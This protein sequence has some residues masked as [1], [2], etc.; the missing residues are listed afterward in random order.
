MNDSRKPRGKTEYYPPGTDMP[1]RSGSSELR[2]DI[3]LTSLGSIFGRNRLVRQTDYVE[4]ANVLARKLAELADTSVEFKRAAGRYGDI[5]NILKDDQAERDAERN[6]RAQERAHHA[7][8]EKLR[9]EREK[10]E[11]MGSRTKAAAE[12]HRQEQQYDELRNKTPEEPPREPTTEEELENWKK[13]KR[14]FLKM[15]A[16]MRWSIINE[17]TELQNE[18]DTNEKYAAWTDEQKEDEK[19]RLELEKEM[20]L[21]DVDNLHQADGTE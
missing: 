21:E 12:R 8:M 6:E 13:S 14:D 9:R 18:I 19:K 1:A 2:R 15:K 4:A 5:Q 20:L 7:D 16:D 10:E 3:P 11:A 17:I